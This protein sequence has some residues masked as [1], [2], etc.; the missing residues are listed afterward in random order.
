MLKSFAGALLALTLAAPGLAQEDSGSSDIPEPRSW[1]ST[2]Q[3]S[4]GGE[5]IRYRVVAGETY[6]RDDDGNPTG[7]IFSTAYL[8]EGVEDPRQRPVAFVFNGGP[9]SA[10]LWLHMGVIGPKRVVLPS[11]PPGDDGAAPFD[12]RDNPETLLTEADLVFIDPVG[13]GWSRAM[14]DTDP[15]EEFWG[16]DQDA[17]SVAEFIRRW[18]AENRRWNSPKYLVGESYGTTRIGALMRQLEAG[19]NDVAINGVVLI[20]VVLDFK[21]DHTAEGNDIGYIGLMPGYAATAWYHNR[22]DRSA[23]NNDYDAFLED[24]RAFATDTYLPALVRGATLSAEREREVIARLSDFIGLSEDYLRRAN[25]RVSLNDFRVELLRDQ[26]LSVGRFDSR[27]TG[28]EPDAISDSPEGDPSGY[29]IDGAYTAAML[30]YFTR[31]LGVDI[32]D[33]YTTLGGVREWN[34]DAGPA[35]GDNSYVNVSPWLERAM[36]QNRDLRVLAT[37][38]IYDLATPFFATEMTFNRPGYDQERV[39]LTYYP[40]GHMMYLHQPSIEQLAED[41][42]DFV[43]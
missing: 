37:N 18:L 27:F 28:I 34:W 8:A 7:S 22:I 30:D 6:L 19:W 5:R 11:E 15:A 25:M 32:T 12:V 17:A 4:A 40:A 29:G 3:I 36:R 16:V 42:R 9:G 41:L 26:G 38:G 21:L 39:E 23:W 2:G 24:A 1:E 31:D 14:G 33:P 10:S 35:G 13:T 43:E 20:S